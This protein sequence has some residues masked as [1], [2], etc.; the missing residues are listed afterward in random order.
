MNKKGLTIIE[1]LAVIVVIA[2]IALIVVP[3]VLGRI[4]TATKDTV[5]EGAINYLKEVEKFIIKNDDAII[6]DSGS[7]NKQLFLKD[8][9]IA[10]EEEKLNGEVCNS[11]EGCFEIDISG[12][13]P[14]AGECKKIISGPKKLQYNYI[15]LTENDEDG[16]YISNYQLCMNGYVVTEDTKNGKPK[17]QTIEQFNEQ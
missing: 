3:A 5:E 11:D 13:L 7:D 6:F 1:L 4:K 2:L 14:N 10:F 8:N 15:F 16:I 12:T 9:R 17:V